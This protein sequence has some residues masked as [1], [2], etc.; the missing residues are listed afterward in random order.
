MIRLVQLSVLIVALLVIRRVLYGWLK[1]RDTLPQLLRQ[2]LNVILLYFAYVLVGLLGFSALAARGFGQGS[3]IVAAL[4]TVGGA[5]YFGLGI[6][7]LWWYLGREEGS[8]ARR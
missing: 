7:A 5:L 4:L 3:T 2:G 8:R 1:Q 6:G